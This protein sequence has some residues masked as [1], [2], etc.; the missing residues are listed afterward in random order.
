MKHYTSDELVE[1][2]HTLG[3]AYA[4]D[5]IILGGKEIIF[6][7]SDNGFKSYKIVFDNWKSVGEFYQKHK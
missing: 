5:R 3:Y 2:M 1:K 4:G 7:A 6:Y